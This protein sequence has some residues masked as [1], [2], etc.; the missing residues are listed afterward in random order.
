MLLQNPSAIG[1]NP[2]LDTFSFVN[3]TNTIFDNISI[4]QN[5]NNTDY[6]DNPFSNFFTSIIATYFWITGDM[7]QR[8]NYRQFIAVEVISIIATIV[9]VTLLQNLLI[10]FMR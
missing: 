9:L 7:S 3:A 8:S 1:V 4:Q 5:F 2:S 10:A 6:T